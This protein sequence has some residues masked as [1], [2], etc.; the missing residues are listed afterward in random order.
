MG[1][2]LFQALLKDVIFH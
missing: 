2:I 1:D